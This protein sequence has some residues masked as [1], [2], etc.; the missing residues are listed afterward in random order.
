[1]ATN[2]SDIPA[3]DWEKPTQ[4]GWK[5]FESHARLMFDGPLSGKSAKIKCS[6]LLLWLGD[7]GREIF[8][9][10]ELDNDDVNDID[11][12]FERFKDYITPEV[13]TVFARYQFFDRNQ[14]SSEK[15][16]DYITALK[17][18]AQ[19]CDYEAFSC[20]SYPERNLKEEMIRD[21]IIAG[22]Q[23]KEVKRK[24]LQK[25]GYLKLKEAIKI[26]HSHEAAQAQLERMS[27]QPIKLEVDAIRQQQRNHARYQQQPAAD[28]QRIT[29]QSSRHSQSPR[30]TTSSTQGQTGRQQSRPC[31][32]CGLPFSRGHAE[33]CQAKGK[34]CFKCHKLGHFREVCRSPAVNVVEEEAENTNQ[35]DT[36]VL[37]CIVV[38][39]VVEP[40]TKPYP[41]GNVLMA[42]GKQE[43]IHTFKLDTGS[44]ANVISEST[45]RKLFKPPFRLTKTNSRLIAYGGTS[46]N[47]IG[48]MDIECSSV[49][50]GKSLILP[51][52]VIKQEAGSIL[53]HHA[54]KALGLV[55]FPYEQVEVNSV[56]TKTLPDNLKEFVDVFQGIGK[57]EGKVSIETRPEV[58]P[59][60]HPPRNVPISRLKRLKQLLDERENEGVIRKVKKPTQW[61]NSMVT[62]EK[63]D[64]SLRLCLDPK[65]LNE[66]IVRPHYPVP[67]FDDISAGVHG[68][69]VFTKLDIKWGYW[70][71]ELDEDASDLTTF[72]TPFGRY[73]H[74]RMPFG[75]VCA[76]D[77][78]QRTVD[79]FIEGLDGVR[80]VADDIVVSGRTQQEHDSNLRALLVRARER[81][82]R[83]NLPKS[84]FSLSSIPWF[85]NLLTADGLKPD[86]EKIKAIEDMPNPK[87]HEELATLIGM[88]NYL[89]RYIPNLST[90]NQPLRELN[91]NKDFLWTDQHTVAM[92]KVR[93]AICTSLSHFDPDASDVELTT[94]A[95]Q[96]GLGAHLSV[97]GNIV[98]Y[99]SKSLNKTEQD[100]AQ[101]EKELYAIVFGCQKFHQYIF[102][103]NI[104]VYTDHKPLEAIFAKPISKSPARLRRMLLAL[105]PY[106][107][108][109]VFKPGREI[110]VADAL[111]RLHAPDDGIITP[112][113]KEIDV[114]VHSVMH[115]LPVRDAKFAAIQKAT[116]DDTAL[117]VLMA[118]IVEGWPNSIKQC[119]QEAIEFW[120]FREELT[121]CSGVVMK[122]D[123]ILIPE[124]MR[125]EILQQLHTPHLGIEKTRQRARQ[126]VFWPGISKAIDE[127]TRQ[128]ES[129]A[130]FAPSNQK[131]PLLSI[132]PPTLPWEHLGCDLMELD[133]VDYLVTSDYYSR[134]F[135]LDLMTS[136]TSA[137]IAEKLSTHFAREGIPQKMRTDNDTRFMSESFQSFLRKMDIQH[138]TSSPIYPKANGHVEKA[139]DIA[140]RILKKAKDAKTD[141]RAG[142]LEYRNTP[143]D[144]FRSP[145]Q[146]LKG[147]QLRSV[148]PCTV[149]H[150]TPKTV[151]PAEL[152]KVRQQHQQRQSCYY[153]RSA[154]PLPPLKA[155]QMVW[156]Q[157]EEKGEWEK[158][159]IKSV[160]DS[161]SY[162]ITTES[163]GEYRRN[164]VHLRPR[165]PGAPRITP[166]H[167]AGPAT[168]TTQAEARPADGPDDAPAQTVPAAAGHP[169]LTMPSA[170]ERNV[171]AAT[172][173][174]ARIKKPCVKLN[175]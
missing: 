105:R 8:S 89:S 45:L 169:G 114:Y 20:P 140:K 138:S 110:P 48:V 64:G 75:L 145:A 108:S 38:D 117:N 70:I 22:I 84:H 173:S 119:P 162:W 36:F 125:Q 155:G 34:E 57:I 41:T 94:D 99:A 6:Y 85:G 61:V 73:Q 47:C 101:I 148:L 104:T 153:D 102:G 55:E 40:R 158:A 43:N 157:L 79:E 10:W 16:S 121:V 139:V 97:K 31:Y 21:K 96:H 137:A 168:E 171:P 68:H 141:F 160:H 111:S 123:R 115:N 3:F 28:P 107:V 112:L 86:P 156:C 23:S 12:Y 130:R 26:I 134:W 53:S 143:V 93:E 164:R 58:K 151:S 83:F 69:K 131:E 87:S 147:R 24:L 14:L 35:S 4:H 175:L 2:L 126:V 66:A 54:C 39:A 17:L 37:E 46:I 113:Q 129:C 19:H 136:T 127:A 5:K 50:S 109:I 124:S 81:N 120:N 7:K 161:R 149:K 59:V 52:F 154:A 11:V 77:I 67:K 159:T 90:I 146:L 49:A 63:P 100:Y 150:L 132:P 62:T 60:V 116:A 18:L 76:Q 118:T 122:G 88:V 133:G 30:Q 92:K 82:V 166:A 128:C 15:T 56:I 167:E 9:T 106:C 74:T 29:Q 32:H 72:N 135:E 152:R 42:L 91:N 95:S 170:R 165:V 98:C 163:G 174:S 71:L 1:M 27:A 33:V 144:G 80:A 44:Q 172:R 78:F 13:N 103:R 65:D 142:L 25:G 51:F